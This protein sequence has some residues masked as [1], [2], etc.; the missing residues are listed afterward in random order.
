MSGALVLVGAG[1]VV[2]LALEAPTLR[3]VA[4]FG[5]ALVF[6]GLALVGALAIMGRH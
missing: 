4:R 6:V 3:K 5:L 1:L 2:G